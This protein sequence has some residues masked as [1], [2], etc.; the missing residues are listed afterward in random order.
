VA[1]AITMNVPPAAAAR[2]MA[3]LGRR[4]P[5]T[6]LCDLLEEAGPRSER[7]LEAEREADEG[8]WLDPA[9]SAPK[10]PSAPKPPSAHPP[11]P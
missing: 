10:A 1:D 5:L 7:I 9:A 4:V 6:L 2:V 3:M 8:W 11:L